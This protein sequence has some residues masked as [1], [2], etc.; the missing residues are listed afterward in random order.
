MAGQK[1][2][3]R[4]SMQASCRLISAIQADLDNGWE[5]TPETPQPPSIAALSDADLLSALAHARHSSVGME[6]L[7]A[8]LWASIERRFDTNA[9]DSLTAL[10][11]A[12]EVEAAEAA[13]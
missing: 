2:S 11:S 9:L 8:A 6:K 13:A 10:V 7:A 1:A 12:L 3:G 5:P 4:E